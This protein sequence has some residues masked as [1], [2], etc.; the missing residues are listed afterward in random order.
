MMRFAALL[1]VAFLLT[2]CDDPV[3]GRWERQELV[4]GCGEHP[5]FEVFDDLTGVG[6]FCQCDYDFF[7]EERASNLYRFDIDFEGICGLV[8]DGN[9]DCDLVR[10]GNELDCGDLGDFV[11]LSD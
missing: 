11:R 5:D 1:T 3:V 9:Y 10:D 2:A 8:G 6:D 4:V 7:V